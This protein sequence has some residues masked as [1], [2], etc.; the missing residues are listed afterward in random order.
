MQRVIAATAVVVGTVLVGTLSAQG[1]SNVR[2]ERLL[3]APIIAPGIHPSVGE[4][5]QG[6]SVIK[7]PDWINDPLGEYYLYFADHKGLYIRLAY[8]D[9]LLGPWKIH[10][11]GS[12]QIRDSYF[13]VEPPAVSP[14]DAARLLASQARRSHD[15]LFE[16][17]T[18]HIASPDVHVDHA[19]ERVIMYFHG[20]DDV[21]TQ[22]S[23]V[24]TSSDGIHFEARPER[25]GR[26]YMRIFNHDGYTYSMAMPGQFYRSRN[27]L[28]NFE[29]GPRLFNANMR[30]SALLIRDNTLF[31]FWT[32]VGDVPEHIMLS[33]IDMSG[34]WESWQQTPGIEVLRPQYEWEGSD[35]PLEPSVRS[36][37]YGV[38]N[39]L[40]DPAIYED[41]ESGRTYLF[42][43]VGGEAGIAVAEIHFD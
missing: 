13:L 41:K 21:S 23:R 10:A 16:A 1:T 18:P 43:A 9:D 27:P 26:T 35:A 2:V 6:P 38:V 19:N 36:T 29:E 5:I 33:T 40:R 25:L 28:G 17:T 30:H 11:P 37:A 39:Q 14:E 3:S 15:G 34:E 24:A 22:V 31:V 42:Y 7:V 32:Q 12:L 20:L 4:N 8:A